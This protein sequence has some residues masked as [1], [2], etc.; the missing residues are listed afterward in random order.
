MTISSTQLRRC[1]QLAMVAIG[2]LLSFSALAA[3]TEA[4]ARYSQERAYC[5][6]GRS[7]QDQATCMKEAGAALQENRR[8]NLSTIDRGQINQNTETRCEV[9][10]GDDKA[11][12]RA[13]MEGMGTTEGSVAGGGI[14]REITITK[15]GQ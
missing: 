5:M 7:Q 2:G 9:L 13:R 6:S 15:P 12:C 1:R 4:Q 10:K 14:L 11:A 3:D 8:G